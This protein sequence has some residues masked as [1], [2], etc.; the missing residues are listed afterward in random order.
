MTYELDP[1][2][3]ALLE[4]KDKRIRDVWKRIEKVHPGRAMVVIFEPEVEMDAVAVDGKVILRY[5]TLAGFYYESPVL[6]RPTWLDVG[7]EANNALLMTGDHHHYYFERII[8]RKPR[9]G[10]P[11]GVLNYQ[12]R[13]GS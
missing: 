9:K 8:R 3:E 12:M 2:E 5:E 11:D 4:V 1:A 7:V 10:Y 6:E 13:F